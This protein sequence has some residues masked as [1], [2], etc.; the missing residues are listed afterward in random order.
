MPKDLS[1]KLLDVVRRQQ[2]EEQEK[3]ERYVGLIGNSL[4]SEFLFA[5]LAIQGCNF[6]LEVVN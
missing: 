1:K 3:Q 2:D 5:L 6:V 4:P